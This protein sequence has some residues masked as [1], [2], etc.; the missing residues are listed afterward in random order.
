MKEQQNQFQEQLVADV[1]ADFEKRRQARL[2]IE[3][4]WRLNM[5]F[6]VGNQFSEINAKGDI[7]ETCKQ[8]YWQERSVF[9]HI[10]PIV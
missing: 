8:F 3:Q 4:A 6:M 9:N 7:D 5:N 2:S 1:K 10:A